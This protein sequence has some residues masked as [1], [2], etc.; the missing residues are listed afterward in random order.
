[1]NENGLPGWT[2]Q[3]RRLLDESA[4][5]LDGASLSRLNRA[6]QAALAQRQPALRPWFVP[7]GLASACAVLLAVAVVWRAPPPMPANGGAQTPI[8]TALQSS[9]FAAGDLDIVSGDDGFEFYQ[10][11]EFYAWLDAQSQEGDG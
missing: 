6:R 2:E 8:A 11:L 5:S 3:A 4:Q 7:A 9:G 10:D 1:M